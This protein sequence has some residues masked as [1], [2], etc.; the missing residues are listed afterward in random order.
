MIRAPKT[1]RRIL[2]SRSDALGDSLLTLPLCG[3]LRE[4]Y[5]AAEIFYLGRGYTRPY[6]EHSRNVSSVL[7]WDE[8]A[9][10]QRRDRPRVLRDLHADVVLHVFPRREIASLGRRAGIP[11]RIGTA[12]R[13]YHW[14]NCTE[15]V[16]VS[17]RDSAWHEA[18]L[19]TL[20]AG[21][22]LGLS[23][24]PPLEAL[25]SRFALVPP[26]PAAAVRARLDAHRFNLVLHP[27]NAQHSARWPLEHFAELV[28]TLPDD[29][30]NVI[31]TGAGG[32]RAVLRS[33]MNAL[34]RP[35]TEAFDLDP[36][37]FM[38]LVAG[39]DGLIAPSTGPLHLAAALGTNALGIFPHADSTSQL[40]RWRPLG[41]RAEVITPRTPCLDCAQLGSEC[42]CLSQVTAADVRTVV[43]GWRAITFAPLRV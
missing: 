14:L 11:R 26:A 43:T 23:E 35:T 6:I 27:L 34:A 9:A 19:N 21:S 37:D 22:L 25:G 7:A 32:D 15:L 39:T 28:R 20:V 30:Y 16:R 40:R 33:W 36:L 38:A 13:W 41:P 2:I 29:E 3:M 12:R 5:P 8:I 31:V 4:R 18:Q 10:L 17:R 42:G 1:P 24:P